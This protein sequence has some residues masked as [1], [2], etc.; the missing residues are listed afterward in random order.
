M[1]GQLQGVVATACKDAFFVADK[2]VRALNQMNLR[3]AREARAA[4][5]A[6]AGA[7]GER[8]GARFRQ[9]SVAMNPAIRA[10]Q[11]HFPLHGTFRT[12]WVHFDCDDDYDDIAAHSIVL[13]VADFVDAPQVLRTA[14]RALSMLGRPYLFSDA[15]DA[16]QGVAL[17][18]LPL[19]YVSAC[20]QHIEVSSRATLETWY[21]LFCR[22]QLRARDTEA[23]MGLPEGKI[24][25]VLE[26]P[27]GDAKAAL[28]EL[29][30][31][32]ARSLLLVC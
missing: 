26:M 2:L 23:V 20:V 18:V 21:D 27:H 15:D 28:K 19:T 30:P 13:S 16:P 12:L 17:L 10:V 8:D 22:G 9:C 7:P 25:D 32:R 29:L 4:G 14:L 31:A 24:R 11:V 3:L 6:A 1:A 5:V